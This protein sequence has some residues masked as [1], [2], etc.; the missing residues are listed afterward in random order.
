MSCIETVSI[1]EC[2]IT[3]YIHKRG[4]GAALSKQEGTGSDI[5]PSRLTEGTLDMGAQKTNFLS[6]TDQ[7]KCISDANFFGSLF[8]FFIFFVCPQVKG[9][10]R[11]QRN[12]W[13][14]APGQAEVGLVNRSTALTGRAVRRLCSVLLCCQRFVVKVI[15]S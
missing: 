4:T 8:Q 9:N 15:A 5:T 11:C 3:V 6:N 12:L 1:I 7:L 13:R 2:V 14:V 10:R